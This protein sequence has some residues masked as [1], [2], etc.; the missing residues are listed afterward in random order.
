MFSVFPESP[1][2]NHHAKEEQ[3]KI[4]YLA[5]LFIL[6]LKINGRA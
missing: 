4:P 1:I 3:N 5:I 2:D 6:L